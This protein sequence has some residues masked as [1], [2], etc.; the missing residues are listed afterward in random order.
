MY[1]NKEN[2]KDNDFA[3]IQLICLTLVCPNLYSWWSTSMEPSSFSEA[4]LL[5]MNC[6]SGITLAFSTLYL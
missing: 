3:I 1:I 5:S 2:A 4:F 6:P